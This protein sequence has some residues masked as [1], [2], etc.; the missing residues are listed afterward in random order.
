MDSFKIQLKKLADRIDAL[1]VRER[2][3]VFITVLVV[4][5]AVGYKTIFEP[6]RIESNQL[7]LSLQDQY[8]KIDATNKELNVMLA[9]TEQGSAQ[10]RSKIEALT[11]QLHNLESEMDRM[12]AGVVTPKE[13]AKLIEQ[14]LSRYH[15]LDLV[16]LE[17]LPPAPVDDIKRAVGEAVPMTSDVIMYRHGMRVELSGR[18]LDILEYLKSLEHLP[19][20]VYWGEVTL[21]TQKYPISKVSLVIYTVSRYPAWIGV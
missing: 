19:W 7:D 2:G 3:F 15:S 4:L 17:A 20:K 5:Y 1:S 12:T 10:N 21:E 6:I 11:L 13:M 16:S 14:M 9:G 18:Y 8:Q